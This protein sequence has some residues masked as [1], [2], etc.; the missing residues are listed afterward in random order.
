MDK[1]KIFLN[2]LQWGFLLWL[3]GY[4]LGFV[5]F[6]FVPKD[7]I[8][9][10]ILPFGV[11]ATLWVLFKKIERDSFGCYVGLGVFWTILALVLDY[12]FIVKLLNSTAY[13]KLDVYVYYILTLVLPIVVGWY[14]FNR[15][16]KT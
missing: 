14:K 9:W 4:A 13:Y 7:L 6:V 15:K 5:F 12:V 2:T 8:G 16:K 1:K 10:A 3:F 11:I